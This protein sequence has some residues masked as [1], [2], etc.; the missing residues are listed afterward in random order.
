M[1]VS[2]DSV[3]FSSSKIKKKFYFDKILVNQPNMIQT[4]DLLMPVFPFTLR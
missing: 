1:I 2:T 4:L 3:R